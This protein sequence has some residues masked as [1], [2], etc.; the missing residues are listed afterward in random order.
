MNRYLGNMRLLV[1]RVTEEMASL[2]EE[3][4]SL[5][6]VQVSNSQED[7]KHKVLENRNEIY[8]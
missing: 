8:V 2:T 5:T 4:A 3:M 1:T 6:A 7:D